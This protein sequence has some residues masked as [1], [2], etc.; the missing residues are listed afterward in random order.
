MKNIS[1]RSFVNKFSVGLGSAAI[2]NTL[3]SF[4]IPPNEQL[5]QYNGKKLN[6]AICGLGNYAEAIADGLQRAQYCSLAG[7]VT[8]T[9]AKAKSWKAKYNIP[10]ENVYDYSN[11][12]TVINNKNIDLVYITL[13]NGMHKEF[14]IRAAI[15][16]KHVITEKPMAISPQD[17]R[18]MIKACK[19][20]GV[21]LAIGY[22]LH[23]E[24]THKELMRIGQDKVFGQVRYIEAGLGYKTYDTTKPV[25]TIDL[26]DH[27]QWRHNKKLS[28][29]GPLMDLGIYCVQAGRYI[30]GE[31]PLSVT[32]QFGT[33]NDP[34]RF[35]EVEET[36][37]WQMYCPG[38]AVV[39]CSTSVGF[40]IDRLY[41]TADEGF[42]ELSPALSYGPFKGRSSKGELIFPKVNQQ[43]K[44]LDG[45]CSLILQGR[46]LPNHITGEEGLKDM[47]IIEAIYKAA[48][49]GKK[50]AINW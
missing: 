18:E 46:P 26:K 38:G 17:C 35:A 15:A 8:G 42:F 32:A 37:T 12:D 1:R 21:Q 50:A 10:D 44:Q 41:A 2:I 36:I 29:G 9:P 6:V 3:P 13:P 27:S 5:P 47:I 4:M 25:K 14:T 19:D 24:P 11:F 7:I 49:S 16:G 45:I 28:G 48:T 43:E 33:V 31:E 23:Y 22:R 30:L 39:N 40:N 20:A 34:V